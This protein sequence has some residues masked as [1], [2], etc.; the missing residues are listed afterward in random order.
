[1]VTGRIARAC[2]AYGG[3]AASLLVACGGKSVATSG[4]DPAN[5]GS[6]GTRASNGGTTS[7]GGTAGTSGVGHDGGAPSTEQLEQQCI[8]ICKRL[9][10][11]GCEDLE[12]DSCTDNC[13][14]AVG[15]GSHSVACARAFFD[16]F[17][18]IEDLPDICSLNTAPM[19]EGTSNDAIECVSVYCRASPEDSD[20]KRIYGAS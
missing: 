2:A 6:S 18:C 15:A 4:E 14:Y 17:R 19:C 5:A 7:G 9:T 1:M 10:A 20:C 11:P 16:Y 3:L 13:I 8:D 12:Y